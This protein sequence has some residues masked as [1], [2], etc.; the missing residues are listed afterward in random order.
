MT[1]DF[2][3]L[4]LPRPLIRALATS[5]ITEPFPIQAATIPDALAGRDVAG[6]APTGSGKTLAFGLPLLATVDRA[7]PGRPCALVLAPTRELADQI[8]R[9]LHPLATAAKRQVTA[10]Y[11][12][13]GYGPQKAALRK[14]ADILV[15]TPGRLEDLIEQ[16]VVD[17][18]RAEIVVIDEADR[19]ADMG[20]LPAVRRILDRT[21]PDRQTLLFSA[22]LDGDVGVLSRQSQRDPVRHEAVAE[23]SD[24]SDA[25]HHFWL[26]QH[27]DRVQHTADVVAAAGRSIVFTRTR[28]GADRLA[29]QL[30]RHGVRVAAIHGGRRQNQRDRALQAFATGRVTA[31]V[32]TD[33]AARGIHV[34]GVSSV[35]HFDPPGDHKDYVHRSGRTARAGAT[36]TVISL[37]TD[38]QRRTATRMVRTLGLEATIQAPSLDGLFSPEDRPV[39]ADHDHRRRPE[40]ARPHEPQRR[41]STRPPQS[42]YVA[43]LP[44]EATA[45]ELLSVFERFGDVRQATIISDKRTGRS[46]GFGFVDMQTT[47]AAKRAVAEAAGARLDGRELTV[48]FAKPRRHRR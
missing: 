40:P 4:G 1:T 7:A 37:I 18:R 20:F 17:L 32:A 10:V 19:M 14:G 42:I 39:G 15:A 24:V 35:V 6:Q 38:G 31:L 29:K 13:V 16:R 22:T 30:D 46:R 26:V 44:F 45:D 5:G 8:K 21:S 33:V 43:N 11:G 3:Q 12:G 34:D 48:R 9:E 41:S 47:D 27:H 25:S 36:G 23:E 28:H 2:A